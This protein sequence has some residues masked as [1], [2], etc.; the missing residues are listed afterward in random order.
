[1]RFPVKERLPKNDQALVQYVM[2]SVV[3]AILLSFVYMGIALKGQLL[4]QL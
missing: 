2:Q 3:D 4:Q 1:M